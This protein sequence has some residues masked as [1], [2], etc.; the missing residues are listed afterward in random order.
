MIT[1]KRKAMNYQEWT[2]YIQQIKKDVL[3]NPAEFLGTDLPD[4]KLTENI[5]DDVFQEYLKEREYLENGSH[6]AH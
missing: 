3:G 4:H 5:I 1:G 6:K 2:S